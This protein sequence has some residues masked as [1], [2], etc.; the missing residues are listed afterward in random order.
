MRLIDNFTVQEIA[1]IIND[2]VSYAEALYKIGYANRSGSN[3]TMIKKYCAE[4]KISCDH[5]SKQ[6][7]RG[8]KRTFEN[9]FCENSTA[10]QEVTKRWYKEG[11]YTDYKCS[12]CGID[13][14]QGKELVLRLDHINGNNKDNRLSNLRWVCPNC[15]SQLDTYC[16][17]NKPR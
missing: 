4:H 13:S 17:R 3:L 5:F 16:G 9:V 12:I 15:D 8:I 6:G 14:W 7:R 10:C 11:Q 2:S 1:D